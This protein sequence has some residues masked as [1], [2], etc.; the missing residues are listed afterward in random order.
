M[1]FMVK[2]IIH[3]VVRIEVRERRGNRNPVLESDRASS[4]EQDPDPQN[5]RPLRK[6]EHCTTPGGTIHID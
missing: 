2:N 4:F 3:L 6:Q 1:S 5:F